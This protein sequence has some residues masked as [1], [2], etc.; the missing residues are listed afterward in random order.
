MAAVMVQAG[1][2]GRSRRKQHVL[3]EGHP[4]QREEGPGSKAQLFTTCQRLCNHLE[5]W[6]SHH[7][8][9]DNTLY[10]LH[11]FLV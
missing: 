1:G 3:W 7:C 4:Q 8:S 5:P 11:R 10:T 9:R 6:I 2:R